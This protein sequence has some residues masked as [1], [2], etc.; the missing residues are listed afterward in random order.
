VAGESQ[1][2]GYA[3]EQSIYY[4]IYLSNGKLTLAAMCLRQVRVPGCTFE[5]D[6]DAC[7]NSRYAASAC[8]TKPV[9]DH[10]LSP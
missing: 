7:A 4:Q 10:A 1:L 9:D 5:G 2:E 8:G 6:A 3:A